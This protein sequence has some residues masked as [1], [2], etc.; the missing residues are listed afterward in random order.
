MISKQETSIFTTS[1]YTFIY[2]YIK[3]RPD[4]PQAR[5]TKQQSK[6]ATDDRT[7]DAFEALLHSMFR[8]AE[9]RGNSTISIVTVLRVDL[10]R[11]MVSEHEWQT[12]AL[13]KD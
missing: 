12:T 1:E 3:Q 7:V 2:N 8:P 13:H 4:I 11:P 10:R 5:R 9:N 6:A